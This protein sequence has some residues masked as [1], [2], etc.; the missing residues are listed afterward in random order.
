MKPPISANLAI[1]TEDPTPWR[2]HDIAGGAQ[3]AASSLCWED[4]WMDKDSHEMIGGR[5]FMDIL[6]HFHP[7][8]PPKKNIQNIY[9]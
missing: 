8:P 2:T 9:C 7:P 6:S 3:W 4:G 1:E 5:G